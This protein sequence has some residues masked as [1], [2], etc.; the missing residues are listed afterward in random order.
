MKEHETYVSEELANKL[1]KAGFDW[2]E[3]YVAHSIYEPFRWEIPLHIAQKWL[4]EV[5]NI[6][7]DVG[8]CYFGGDGYAVEWTI[9]NTTTPLLVNQEYEYADLKKF[10]TYE[11]A[12]EDVINYVIN[13]IVC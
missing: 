13:N 6:K 10:D 5:K 8:S 9:G 1:V 11:H 3:Y 12:L 4:R 2:K 7:I